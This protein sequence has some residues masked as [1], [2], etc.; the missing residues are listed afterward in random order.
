MDQQPRN[1]IVHNGARGG[2]IL[3]LVFLVLFYASVYGI[4]NFLLSLVGI[5]AFFAVPLI[6][7]RIMRYS[8]AAGGCRMQFA[9]VWLEGILMFLFG[10]MILSVGAYVFFRWIDPDYIMRMLRIYVDMSEKN[11]VSD[12]LTDAARQI[13][14]INYMPK[15]I[16]MIMSIIW[17]VGFSGSILSLILTPIVRMRSWYKNG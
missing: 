11:G 7:F 17:A 10:A 6:A 4:N 16:D 3:G 1:M 12:G 2:L 8:Y 15:P 5:A 14:E 9:G 13:L